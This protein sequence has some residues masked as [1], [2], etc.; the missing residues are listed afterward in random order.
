VAGICSASPGALGG[1]RSLL[2]TRDALSKF[3]LW[4]APSQVAVGRADA[5]FDA[6]G[7]LVDKRQRKAVLAVGTEVARAAARFAG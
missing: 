1:L 7:E 6:A 2:V 5:A 3:G 4:V